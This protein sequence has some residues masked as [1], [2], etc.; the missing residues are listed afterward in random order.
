MIRNL[1]CL[2]YVLT[3]PLLSTAGVIHL[4]PNGND[5]ADG[6]AEHPL[7]TP[8]AALKMAREWRRTADPRS[9][10]GIEIVFTA[11]RYLLDSPLYLRPE[12]SGTA[13]A[14]TTLRAAQGCE[15]KVFLAPA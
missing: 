4:A 9:E 12:D 11:G 8:H 1:I 6:S 10:G 5:R 14:P 3:M 2:L 7:R 15:G 13:D